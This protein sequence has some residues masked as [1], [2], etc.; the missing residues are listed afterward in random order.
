MQCVRW[1]L[2]CLCTLAFGVA[3]GA[4]WY[5][6]NVRGDDAGAGTEAAPFKTIAKATA[7]A[8]KSDTIYLTANP[9]PYREAVLLNKGGTAEQPFI[10]DGRGATIDRR[11]HYTVD[12]WKDEGDGVYSMPL[13]NNAHVMDKQWWGFD[14]VFFDGKAGTNCASR[15]AL[16]PLGYFLFKSRIPVDGKFHPLH[17]TLYIKLPAGKTP[18]DIAVVAPGTSTTVGVEWAPY[19]TVRNVTA[20]Y[21]TGDGF[22]TWRTVGSVFEHVRGCYNMDQGISQHGAQVVVRDS[23]FDHNAGCGIVDI[24]DE[25]KVRYERCLVEDDIFRGGVEFHSGEYSMD[26]CVIRNNTSKALSLNLSARVTLTNCLFLGPEGGKYSG[27]YTGGTGTLT[28]DR[29]TFMRFGTAL[30]VGIET[31][32]ATVTNCAFLQCAQA[33]QVQ[34]VKPDLTQELTFD[35]NALADLPCTIR[36]VTYKPDQWATFRE[37]TGFE[38]H[39]LLQKL[40]GEE[41]PYALPTLVGKG[42]DGANIGATIPKDAVYGP[43]EAKP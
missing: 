2:L 16:I 39:G 24:F 30:I 19:V 12:K 29:C 32:A 25:A 34:P 13:P 37:K 31:R 8:Q 6:D 43:V 9:E 3:Q 23:R 5:V 4:A 15:E 18:A 38:A 11:T 22:G 42:K 28:L 1:A 40:E 33:Y 27:I 20:M 35:Y 36:G 10:F 21:S 26:S 14:L 7:T 41:L 17:N